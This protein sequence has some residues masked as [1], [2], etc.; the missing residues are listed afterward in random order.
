MNN[1][2]KLLIAALAMASAA[3]VNAAALVYRPEGDAIV[4]DDCQHWNNRP[5]YC[6]ERFP[7]VWAGEMPALMGEMGTIYFGFER[8]GT[9]VLLQHFAKRRMRYR[10]GTIIWEFS[11]DRFPAL[12]LTVTGA[13]LAD[14][15]GAVARVVA[16]GTQ[17]GDR[18]FNLFYP[19]NPERR[20]ARKLSAGVA[21]LTW[22]ADAKRPLSRIDARWSGEAKE[23]A[24][25]RYGD[26]EHIARLTPTI[27]VRG[28]R[29]VEEMSE[30]QPTG[31][32]FASFDLGPE[33]HYVAYATSDDDVSANGQMV[34]RRQVLDMAKIA[35]PKKAFAEAMARTEDF[36]T[37][38][39]VETPDPYFNAAMPA[40]VAASAGIFVNPCFVHGGSRWRHQQPGWR[41]MGGAICYAW[42]DQVLRALK[43][44]SARQVKDNGGRTKFENLP[45][46]SQQSTRSIFYGTGFLKYGGAPHYDFQTQFFD[47]AV[48]AWRATGDAEI[49]RVL[50]PMLELHIQYLK[51][52][53][54][55][56][57]D[58][59]YESYNNC[60]PS[61]SIGFNGGPT[62]EES[63]YAY[64]ALRAAADMCR[65]E[66]DVERARRHA[67]DAERTCRALNARLWCEERGQYAASIE[68]GGLHRQLPEAW[69]YAQCVPIEAG[70]VPSVR[71]WQAMFGTKSRLE[72]FILPYGGEMRQTSNY[73]PG[74]WSIRE[75]FG[76]DCFMMA[77]SYFLIGQGDEG[78]SLLR[79]TMVES[80]YG[81][82]T[83]K[84]GYGNER[85]IGKT[86]NYLTPG[87]LSH[88]NCAID[89]SDISSMF[90]RAVVEGLF[91][92]RPDYPN[93]KVV[94]APTFPSEWKKASIRTPAYSLAKEGGQY[95]VGLR[96]KAAVEF[97]I[98]VRCE[99]VAKVM[100]NGQTC[101]YRLEAGPECTFVCVKAGTI[102]EATLELVAEGTLPA[103]TLPANPTRDARLVASEK[104]GQ[105]P[106]FTFAEVATPGWQW[107]SLLREVPKGEKLEPLEVSSAFNCDVRDIFRQEYLSPRTDTCS[108][109]IAKDGWSVWTFQWW[110]I[111]PPTIKLDLPAKPTPQNYAIA[112]AKRNIAFTSS[113]DNFPNEVVIP[114]GRQAKSIW[115]LVAGNTP[116]QQNR[117]AAGEIVFRYASGVEE[118][119][120][121]VPPMNFWPLCGFGRVDYN[122]ARDGFALPP[123]PPAQI[124]LGENCRA[125][126]YGWK[127]R[128]EKLESVTLRTL[129]QECI[130]G[131]MAI[132]LG[133]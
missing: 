124:Q 25:L 88:P 3:G 111:K 96:K 16:E 31:G 13:T 48:R 43:H 105:A 69:A 11:D 78:W 81:D 44:W 60:W 84:T 47:E 122:Y 56:D 68:S 7:L 37:R 75:L 57:G 32:L 58:G 24:Q 40:A 80:M 119:L 53:F 52:N 73:V 23:F 4:R 98:P 50:H 79:G 99:K 91:G 131:L 97:R 113:W 39:K 90:A 65:L 9:K 45:S 15:N 19:V 129:S 30:L 118:K 62:P 17:R 107:P 18:V 102:N 33:P 14:A 77:L 109:R 92:Y 72:R 120:E 101:E 1:K 112:A 6:H 42:P 126:S 27:A 8:K 12:K 21:S 94:V 38:V 54:D 26:R 34:P 130:L 10:G 63:A 28:R 133:K 89:F 115:L 95:R 46:L 41:N 67:E 132:S 123:Q 66:G 83:P 108:M 85:Q 76:G 22:A 35:D 106:R 100:L 71:A 116:P 103:S 121:I 117:I 36:A 70:M 74:Q 93:G 104:Q 125:M 61:D 87:G 82:L 5:L 59:L 49:Q 64:Y 128:D 29:V 114:V 55:P 110:G 51:R 20:K 86:A 2:A 127:L